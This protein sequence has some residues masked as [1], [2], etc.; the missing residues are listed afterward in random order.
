MTVGKLY[1]L[2]IV[3]VLPGDT[4]YGK[5]ACVSRV[6]SSFIRP[7]MDNLF[8]DIYHFYVPLRI[9]STN[10][11]NIFGNPNPTS[12]T[13]ARGG[14]SPAPYFQSSITIVPG[15]VGDYLGLPIGTL[16]P[17]ISALPFRAFAKIWNCWFRNENIDAETY[18][19][20]TLG[21]ILSTDSENPNGSSWSATNYTG[22]LPDVCKIK[23]IFTSC[24]PAPQKGLAVSALLS[25][26]APV[27]TASAPT[28]TP[29]SP[30]GL[31]WFGFGSGTTPISSPGNLVL[32]TAGT[33][34]Y[35]SGSQGTVADNLAPANL[36]ADLS[37]AAGFS[38]NDL[39][40]AFQLQRVL[41]RDARCGSRYNE[42]MRAVYGV[43]FPDGRAQIPEY[44]GGGRIPIGI[45]QVA[46]TSASPSTPTLDDNLGQVAGASLSNGFSKCRVAVPEHGYVITVGCIRHIHSYAEGTQKLWRRT[47]RE[48]FY[49]PAYAHLGEQ[50]VLVDRLMSTAGGALT[51]V[52][53]YQEYGAEYRYLENRVTGQMRPKVTNSFKIYAFTDTYSSAPTL[54]S[55]FI[56]ETY[57]FVDD[58]LAVKHGTGAGA[59]NIDQFLADLYFDDEA[60]RVMPLY[61]TPGYIDH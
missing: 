48:D 43:N 7:V 58:T 29:S 16:Q 39:R 26:M 15:S 9:L 5:T 57:G 40:F 52:F 8:M 46:Q 14:T 31:K 45:Q 44:I 56:H 12:Y 53:G 4:F 54:S 32:G 38:I 19:K 60:I 17:G 2:D 30:A 13:A 55:S 25:G 35:I 51:T 36:Y 1:P 10:A 50:P 18:V 3:E 49:D 28:Y 47:V 41:E 61:S 59:L 42:I 33:T 37:S 22:M 21:P 6:T 11:T 20:T 24:L 27:K 34:G 23:D